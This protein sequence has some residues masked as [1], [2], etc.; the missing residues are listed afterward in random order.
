[1]IFSFYEKSVSYITV[2]TMY[3]FSK[4]C[5]F[6]IS[7]LKMSY[8]NWVFHIL[9]NMAFQL[10]E[11]QYFDWF[12]KQEEELEVL[13]NIKVVTRIFRVLIVS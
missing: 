2:N 7:K 11:I 5:T 3:I 10:K 13:S 4:L 1:M 8:R 9:I 6:Y 12:D